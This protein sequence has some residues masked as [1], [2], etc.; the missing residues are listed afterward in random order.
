MKERKYSCSSNTDNHTPAEDREHN[1]DPGGPGMTGAS[2]GRN[3][4]F[5]YRLS[6]AAIPHPDQVWIA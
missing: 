3:K 2:I 6:Q 4:L 5:S 1:N